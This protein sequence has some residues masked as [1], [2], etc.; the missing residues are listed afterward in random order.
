MTWAGPDPRPA[1]GP[2]SDLTDARLR[3]Q[4]SLRPADPGRDSPARSTRS[5]PSR[6]ATTLLSKA[7]AGAIAG[8]TTV[9]NDYWTRQAERPSNSPS[10]RWSGSGDRMS[11]AW[12]VLGVTPGSRR[13]ASIRSVRTT[14][15]HACQGARFRGR[16]AT[17]AAPF[18]G[19][20]HSCRGSNTCQAQGGCGFVQVT[21]GG[22]NCSGSVRQAPSGNAARYK[23]ALRLDGPRRRR[24]KALF[25]AERQQMRRPWAA[26]P[27]R[28]RPRRS[29]P[30]RGRC[31]FTTSSPAR[32]GKL[33]GRSV[34]D[35][36]LQGRR[37]GPRRR[38]SRLRRGDGASRQDGA[39]RSARAERAPAR[40]PAVDLMA[41]RTRGL[42][43]A[44]PNLGDGVGLRDRISR[45]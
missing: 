39:A 44:V 12:A 15:Y 8:V 1:N 14:L 28:S 42:G 6:T 21:T 32:P 13:S 10:R 9:L 25:R 29:F 7:A 3:R 45:I 19:V 33:A 37:E 36:H 41:R 2:P 4:Q 17:M 35:H 18:V 26:A 5:P 16:A 11:I 20:F 34:H 27:C 24:R 31:S 30:A 43:R 22:G 38:L 40:L 23:R